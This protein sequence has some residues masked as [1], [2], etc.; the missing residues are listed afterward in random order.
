[1]ANRGSNAFRITAKKDLLSGKIKRGTSFK[2]FSDHPR[3]PS[4]ADVQTA[5]KEAGIS[6]G[7]FN[8]PNAD[9]S[10]WMIEKL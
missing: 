9:A 10:N 4:H 7:F 1:M 2:V 5:I 8:K 3:T 6:F